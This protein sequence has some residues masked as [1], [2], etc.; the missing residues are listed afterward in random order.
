[1]NSFNNP[2]YLT[3]SITSKA[4]LTYVLEEP[5]LP[6]SVSDGALFPILAQHTT[7]YDVLK[8]WVF[9]VIPC[10]FSTNWLQ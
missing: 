3:M 10:V 7:R 6:F 4:N 5:E 9:A 8:T 1:M 2:S